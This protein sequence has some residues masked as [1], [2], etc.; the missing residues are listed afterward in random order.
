MYQSANIAAF[1][2]CA[3]DMRADSLLRHVLRRRNHLVAA[4]LRRR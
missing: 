3:D 1:A 2:A 4:R